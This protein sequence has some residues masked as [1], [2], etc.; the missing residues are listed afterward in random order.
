LSEPLTTHAL[1]SRLLALCDLT[2]AVRLEL[3]KTAACALVAANSEKAHTPRMLTSLARASEAIRQ[4]Q[5]AIGVAAAQIN[6]IATYD[7]PAN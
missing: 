4:A 6:Q 2:E 3:Q 1:L 7:H 5:Q